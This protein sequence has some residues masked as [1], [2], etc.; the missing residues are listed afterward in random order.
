MSFTAAVLTISDKGSRGEREDTSGPALCAMLAEAGYEVVYT[1]ILPDEYDEI[2]E[3]LM[4]LADDGVA[5]LILTTGGT[6]FSPRDVTPEATR[7]AIEREA[8]G[9][10]EYMRMKSMEVTPHGALSRG[11]SGLRGGTLI[12][13]LP[14]SR[15]AATENLSFILPS[16]KHGLEIL[17]SGGSADCGEGDAGGRH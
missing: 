13:N 14:G 9:L 5:A 6:G 2:R 11:V 1:E 16:L 10:A 3:R 4:Q 8:P 15:R 12:I 17:H 7:D